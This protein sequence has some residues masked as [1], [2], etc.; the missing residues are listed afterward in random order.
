MHEPQFEEDE[1]RVN[2]PLVILIVV[3]SI[4]AL[5]VV[6]PVAIAVGAVGY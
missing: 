1:S 4:I 6:V 5:V 2:W 3:I